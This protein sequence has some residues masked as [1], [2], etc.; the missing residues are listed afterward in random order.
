VPG[1]KFVIMVRDG[2]DVTA[3]LGK[4]QSGNFA[5]GLERWVV[6]TAIAVEERDSPDV[7]V[8]TYEALV[9]DTVGTLQRLCAFLGL[10][11]DEGMLGYHTRPR[12]WFGRSEIRRTSGVGDA[13]KD[14]RNWQVN[15]PL[16]DGRGRWRAQ[17]PPEIVSRFS[18]GRP[19]VI[20]DAFGYTLD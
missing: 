8:L 2:R 18:T 14:L 9:T 16:F 12:L 3:S 6:D 5:A 7:L 17:L 20:M 13:H 1:A 10:P 4:R 19:R 11:Y 15:Q